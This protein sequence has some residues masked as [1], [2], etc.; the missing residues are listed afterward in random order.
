MKTFKRVLIVVLTLTIMVCMLVLPA[1]AKEAAEMSIEP[2]YPVL[3]CP[4]CG[5]TIRI[6]EREEV[7]PV[8]KACAMD[9]RVHLHHDYYTIEYGTCS[10]GYTVY[11]ETKTKSVC[12]DGV[13]R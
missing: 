13:P 10:C 9:Y 1:A 8:Y 3:Q 5:E 2:R 4:D 11:K 7:R 12:I 6:Y